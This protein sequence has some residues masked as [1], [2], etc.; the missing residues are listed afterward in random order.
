MMSSNSQS[1]DLR[2]VPC[3]L[4]FVK[5]KLRLERLQSGQLLELWLDQGEPVEQVPNSLK[6][7]G[8]KIL[9]LTEHDQKFFTLVVEKV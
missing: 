2:G 6:I 7:D 8:H 4:S 1:L 3:P 9:S 5:A